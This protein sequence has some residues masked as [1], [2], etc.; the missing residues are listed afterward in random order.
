MDNRISRDAFTNKSHYP[1]K[2]EP[3]LK[4][5]SDL[6]EKK[7]TFLQAYSRKV[8]NQK[9]TKGLLYLYQKSLPSKL[10]LNTTNFLL[11]YFQEKFKKELRV[12]FKCCFG[13][14]RRASMDYS[15]T[16]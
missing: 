2:P 3:I 6:S 14:D 11:N 13:E 1:S 4:E 16:V 8:F 7:E 15:N 10:K 12:K 9:L 5:Y